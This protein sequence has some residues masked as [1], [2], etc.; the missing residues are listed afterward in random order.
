MIFGEIGYVCARMA[1]MQIL[2]GLDVQ[3]ES[4]INEKLF[5]NLMIKDFVFGHVYDLFAI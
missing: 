4:I 5:C 2:I 3:S 1:E